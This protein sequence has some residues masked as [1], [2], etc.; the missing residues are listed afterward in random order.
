MELT[1]IIHPVGQG[2]F[3]SETFKNGSEE[4]NVVY[5]C[6]GNNKTSMIYYLDKYYPNNT[7]TIDAVFISHFHDDHINGLEYLLNSFNVKY[8]FL[9]QLTQDE[10][11]E[12]LLYNGL[13]NTTN[14][15]NSFLN[16]LWASGDYYRETRIIWVEHSNGD[17]RASGE[18]IENE[19]L[20]ISKEVK[21]PIV[22]SGAG[23]HICGKWLLIPYN[24]PIKTDKNQGFYE[25]FKRQLSIDDF[26]LEDI[27]DIVKEKGILKCKKVYSDYF[28]KNHNAY[29]M[30]LFSGIAGGYPDCR[31]ECSCHRYAYCHCLR[32]LGR[33]RRSFYCMPNCLYTGDFDVRN[34]VEMPSFYDSF[35]E[36][37]GSIQ[38]PHHGSRNDYYPKLYQFA[39]KGFVS[40]GERN[41]YHHPNVD[42]L[43]GIQGMGCN[44]V[45]VTESLGTMKMYHYY[46]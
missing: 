29:S 46:I 38:V 27:S 9:P 14:S 3:Y 40:V 28:G 17:D 26:E 30:A 20:D 13:K 33:N 2:G 42:T 21:V 10:Q 32:Q 41:R 15:V 36:T 37:I 8:L 22:K 39:S 12:V 44:P 7:K 35:W 16:K 4:F 6:G 18:V 23:L 25:F 31:Y 19:A 11:L 43:I 5:D 34:Q 45:I 24:P 1:R